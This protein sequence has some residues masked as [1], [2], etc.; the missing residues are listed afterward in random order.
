MRWLRRR[1]REPKGPTITLQE[2]L[3]GGLV[4]FEL[5]GAGEG[6]TSRVKLRIIKLTDDPLTILVPRGTEFVPVER[7]EG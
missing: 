1:R 7:R 4:K 2:A 6:V 5:R 3:S